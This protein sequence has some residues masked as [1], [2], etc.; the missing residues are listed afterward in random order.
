MR[1][2]ESEFQLKLMFFNKF[3]TLE[4]DNNL[5]CVVLCG[6]FLGSDLILDFGEV[7]QLCGT[8]QHYGTFKTGQIS[9]R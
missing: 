7:S 2:R 5:D 1:L 8:N 4:G 6:N 9:I 3:K